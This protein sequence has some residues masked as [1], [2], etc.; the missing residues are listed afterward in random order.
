M[1]SII[2]PSY[3]YDV[4][5]LVTELH[6]QCTTLAINFEILVRDDCSKNQ[7]KNFTINKLPNCSYSIS[8]KNN[9]L[10]QTR[11]YLINQAKY[12]YVLLLDNDVFPQN[13]NFVEAYLNALSEEFC[14][15]FGGIAYKKEEPLNSEKLR[16]V[17]GIARE[18]ETASQRI[19][20]N[21]LLFLSSNTLFKKHIFE[22]ITYDN[23][24][25][26][27]GY[28]DLVFSKDASKNKIKVKHLDNPVWHLKLDTS[29][30]YLEKTE[31]ALKTLKNL[32]S[33][34]KLTFQDT[35]ITKTYIKLKD[36]KLIPVLLFVSNLFNVPKILRKNLLSN[37]PKMS[38]FDF[39]RLL[40]FSN[41]MKR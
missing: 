18:E 28:E 41:L 21:E 3:N 34:N 20:K 15:Y 38:Y 23:E 4:Y 17:Y 24:I 8:N 9:G 12:T 16:W 36:K 27:Y 35:G 26:T 29:E 31:T 13:K 32:I 22:V 40:Y 25:I 19:S 10:A 30:V 33:T 11:N 14:I 2:I 5:E 1:L 39:Y 7:Y 6:S 37:T